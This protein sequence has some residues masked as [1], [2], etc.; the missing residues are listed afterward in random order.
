MIFIF[1][2]DKVLKWFFF[3]LN[4]KKVLVTGGAGFIGSQI[5]DELIDLGYEVF[6]L[7]NLSSGKKEYLNPQAKFYLIDITQDLEKVFSL[8]NPEIVVHCAAQ[9]MLRKSLEYPL[10][11]AK[12]NIFGTLGLLE[13]CR[14][15]NVKKIVYCSTGGARVG[16]PQYL[17]VDEN[18]PI[19]PLSPYG[20]SK[21]TAEHYVEAYG[22]LYNLDYLI[23]CFGNV[24]GP[25]DN[26]ASKRLAPLFI[27][28]MMKNQQPSI[29]GDGNQTRDFL[30][31]RDLAKF[32]ASNIEKSPKHKLF[33]IANGEQTSVNKIFSIL[34]SLLNY[35]QQPLHQPPIV[36]EVRDIV[37]D[38]KLAKEELGWNPQYSIEAGLEETI[39]WFRENTSA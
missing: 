27:S 25:R 23:F 33:H 4:M 9:V 10:E 39:K 28:L 13:A 21:H 17:P 34:Q 36:G 7:D 12:I 8:I 2:I 31:V 1:P 26:P 19:K 16:E 32:I 14:K 20:I 6:I 24:Y 3:I 37:L 38:T 11:D 35:A 29:F 30:Y 15:F 22:K 5:V 18:H